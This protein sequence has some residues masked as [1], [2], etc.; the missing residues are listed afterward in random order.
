M[1]LTLSIFSGIFLLVLGAGLTFWSYVN[2]DPITGEYVAWFK[3]IL[4][5]VVS[6]VAGLIQRHMEDQPL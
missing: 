5:G 1:N 3:M 4:V 2:R 6:I